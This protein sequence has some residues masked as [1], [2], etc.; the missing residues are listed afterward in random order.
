[1]VLHCYI[2]T[3]DLKHNPGW[4]VFPFYDLSWNILISH[5]EESPVVVNV[6]GAIGACEFEIIVHQV[7]VHFFKVCTSVVVTGLF[8]F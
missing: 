6:R 8:S 7:T 1:M 4:I 3:T 5:R 2:E